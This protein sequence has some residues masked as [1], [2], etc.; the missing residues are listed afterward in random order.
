M[1]VSQAGTYVLAIGGRVTVDVGGSSAS[2]SIGMKFSTG[3]SGASV[4][5]YLKGNES[6]DSD[7]VDVQRVIFMAAGQSI[8]FG[9]N[10]RNASITSGPWF[11]LVK[12]S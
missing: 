10:A 2:G 5:A 11:S 9:L 8:S 6:F 7:I 1:A 12:V 4:Y 3:G